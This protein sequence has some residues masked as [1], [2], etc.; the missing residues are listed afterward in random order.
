VSGADRPEP[1]EEVGA[2]LREVLAQPRMRPGVS[3]GRLVRAW[4]DVVGPDLVRETRPVALEEGGLVV[5]VSTAAWAVQV[6][7]LAEEVRR[8]ANEMLGAE[9]VRS[10]RVT[11]HQGTRKP[12]GRNASG[13]SSGDA[14][15]P[16]EGPPR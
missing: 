3:L 4:E 12:L 9:M 2:V 11:V 10:V 13:M 14:S 1:P 6:R 15:M 7:F 5:A 16:R 8:R